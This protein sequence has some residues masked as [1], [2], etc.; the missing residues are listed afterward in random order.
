MSRPW[1]TACTAVCKEDPR[2]AR[3]LYITYPEDSMPLYI[4]VECG[5]AA[6]V[7]PT[8]LLWSGARGRPFSF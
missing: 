3:Y 2:C 8:C 7:P 5:A 6:L 4:Y 1:C